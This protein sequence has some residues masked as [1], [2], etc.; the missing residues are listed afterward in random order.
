MTARHWA[1]AAGLLLVALAGCS[2]GTVSTPS[3]EPTPS[4][5]A[6]TPSASASVSGIP[7]IVSPARWAAIEK[8]LLSRGVDA[9]PALVS[10]E[11][12]TWR[13][14]ALGCPRPGMQYT[15]ALVDG[16]QVIVEAGGQQ[17][18]Y[19]FGTGDTPR[20]CRPQR[21]GASTRPS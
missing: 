3:E 18:D 9:T 11:A 15:Q 4:S 12:V 7:S 21:P 20:L 17:Y 8:D 6:P 1:L 14:G 19:R 5:S 2:G 16:M 13:D 10:A